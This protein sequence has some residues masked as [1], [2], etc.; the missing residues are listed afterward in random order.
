MLPKR[1]VELLAV[2]RDAC[3]EIS[4]IWLLGSR[5]DGRARDSSEWDF[6]A[7]GSRTTVETLRGLS[8]LHA[9]DVDILVVTDGE[10]FE[11]AWGTRLRT[12]SLSQW[13]WTALEDEAYY[14]EAKRTGSERNGSVV[15]TRGKA[16]RVD[17]LGG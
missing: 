14:T 16:L 5:A 7:F 4:S 10:R 6:L 9:P 15:R 3:P 8:A 17:S 2:I 13:E 11:N 1:I 12:G